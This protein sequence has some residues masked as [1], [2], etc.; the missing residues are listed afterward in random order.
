MHV[1]VA[2]A[3]TGLDGRHG[4]VA[5]DGVDQARP[6]ARDDDVDEAAGLDQVRDA[7]PVG[8]GQQLHR[9]GVQPLGH[10]RGA[11]RGHECRVGPR[12]RRTTAQQHGVARL[13]REPERVDR[14]VRPA[15]V[16]HAD[17]TERNA[18]LAHLQAVGQRAAA[19]HLADRVGQAG[20]LT[21]S[22]GDAVDA[23]GFSAS[24]SSIAL[25]GA[26]SAGGVEIFGVGGQD[27]VDAA[28]AR[29]RRPHAAPG[30]WSRCSACQRAGRD[31]GAAGGVVYLPSATRASASALC[32]LINPASRSCPPAFDT[33]QV[34]GLGYFD[35]LAGAGLRGR[36]C[37]RRPA[38]TVGALPRP[39]Q[40]VLASSVSSAP[41]GKGGNQAVAAARAG[42]SVHLVAALGDDAAA[43]AARP[44][45]RQW[46]RTRRGGDRA[47]AQR[48]GG[49]RRRRRGREHHRR[50]AR[51]QRAPHVTSAD[52]RAVVADGDVVLIQLEIPIET[53]LAAARVARDAGAVVI[54]N[55]SPAGADRTTW[56][57][58]P[59]SPT[60]SSPTKPRRANGV[61][62]YR[63][64]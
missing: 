5:D 3:D 46:C 42:A 54:V 21:Q 36:Q 28:R 57:P 25:G 51:R 2:V 34:A 62:R 64:W 18:L 6:A 45:A 17:D 13:Q 38:F 24:R 33:C 59:N 50:R 53:A 31:A 52:V 60:S 20:D 43:G 37:E 30:S 35:S 49:D 55:A 12:R 15:L 44:P 47:R 27:L 41:G 29:R 48:R 10:Q 11:Q 40:T 26:R 16:D 9:V 19:Q 22:G 14:D 56:R 39:G 23:L 58:C 4:G 63:I 1:D 7:G 8:A 32:T 61:G